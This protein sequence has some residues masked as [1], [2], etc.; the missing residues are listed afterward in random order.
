MEIAGL[1]CP[2]GVT[3]FKVNVEKYKP[4][5]GAML[6][7][8][9]FVKSGCN[10]SVKAITDYFG[11]RTVYTA[12]FKLF[13]GLWQNV[14]TEINNFKT[15]EGLGLKSYENLQ[16]LEFSADEEFLINNILWV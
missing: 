8:D 2:T 10:F 7:F 16:A 11:A 9:V 4:L 1:F 5:Q 6:M 15:A 3:T 13:G 12:Q 14:K